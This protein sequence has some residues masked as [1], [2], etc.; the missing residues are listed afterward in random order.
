MQQ[1]FD[2]VVSAK[3]RVFDLNIKELWKYKD[4]IAL[5][6]RRNFVSSYKQTIL[7]PLWAIIQPL[8]TTVV[9]TVVFGNLAG[10]A[11]DGIPSFLFYFCA[12]IAWGYFS[13][14]LTAT[15][16][17][18]T[19][20]A[21]ILGKVYFPRLVMPISTVLSQLI[22]FVIQFVFFIVFLIIFLATGSNVTPNWFILM[23]PVL[24]LHM[25]ALSLGVGIIISAMTTKYRDLAMV[26]GFG[27]QLWM[28][29]TPVAYDLSIIPEKF[30]SI[31][32]LNPVTPIISMFR[33]A[34]LGY[35]EPQWIYYGISCIVTVIVLFIGVLIF[36]RVEKTFMDTV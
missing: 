17:T 33:Y 35:G 5:F 9:F 20:N 13:S 28:Y 30:M 32:M 16:H 23:T 31:Y 22:S 24:L 27:V 14:C 7:G 18:F 11:P 25:A 26:V 36:N 4:L 1:E 8:L 6:V 19:A 10:L 21:G 2:V 15:S 3:K 34:F 12:S 29:A